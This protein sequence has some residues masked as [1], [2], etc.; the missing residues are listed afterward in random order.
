MDKGVIEAVRK[1]RGRINTETKI[2]IILGSGLGTLVDEMRDTVKIKFDEI[3]NFPVS[4]VEGHKG[5]VVFGSFSGVNVLAFS[6]R[7]HYYEGYSMQKVCFPVRVMA[8]L[9]VEILVITNVSGA[10]NES[11]SPGDIIVI[12]DHINL[13][14]DNPLRGTTHFVD[15]TEAYSRELRALAHDAADRLGIKLREGVYLGLSGPSYETP[16]EIRML[17]NMGADI[18]GMSTVPEVIMAKSLGMRVLGLSMITNMAA[19]MTGMPLSHKAII[20]TAENAADELK[21]LVSGIIQNLN[22][23]LES[24]K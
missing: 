16:A 11:F 20:E 9:G 7:V 13:M 12:S 6:G 21:G 14:G 22:S 4:S 23:K 3:P 19:G 10:V 8:G 5:E 15:M 1:I 2:G 18:V 17:R 24:D